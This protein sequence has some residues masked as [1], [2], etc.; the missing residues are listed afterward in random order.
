MSKEFELFKV[1]VS[2]IFLG[3]KGF[4]PPRDAR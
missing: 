2:I 4:S 3:T 1:K